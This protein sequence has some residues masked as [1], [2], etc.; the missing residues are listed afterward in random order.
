MLVRKRKKSD[1][2]SL[3]V[4]M[5]AGAVMMEISMEGSQKFKD[6]HNYHVTQVPLFW[7]SS[8]CRGVL[9]IVYC[10]TFLSRQEMESV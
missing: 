8:Y 3:L 1:L 7:I 10:S 4:G 2:Y 9:N 5:Q 6:M